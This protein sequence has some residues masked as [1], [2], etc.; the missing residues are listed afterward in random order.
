MADFERRGFR[1]DRPEQRALLETHARAFLDGFNLAV[2]GWRSP[3]ETLLTIPDGERGFAYEGAAM[4]AAMRD[5]ATG[6]Q[7]RAFQR[8]GSGP[9]DAYIHL[10][11]VG[12]GWALAPLRLPLPVPLPTTPLLR[13]L[14]LDGA[15]FAESFF[16]GIH[17][18]RKICARRPDP[19]WAEKVAGCG[20]ALWF[21]E[22]GFVPGVRRRISDVPAAARPHLWSGI[23]LASC[24]AG[25][26][27][28]EGFGELRDAS[29]PQWPHLAQGCLFAIAARARSGIVPE[30]TRVGAAAL[31][32]A[33]VRTA[34]EWT[35][36][37][38]EGLVDRTDITAYAEWKSRLRHIALDR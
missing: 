36:Q 9:G 16:G 20:R 4:H 24:Y 37:A 26:L 29:G 17:R 5:L 18:L 12:H 1:L 30:H 21:I 33:D 6:G 35:D 10:I 38:A 32:A 28:A 13:W 23:G 25:G 11:H 22:S 7:A 19:R 8:L 2:L 3:H 34:A 27:D 14:G 15:G 31:F